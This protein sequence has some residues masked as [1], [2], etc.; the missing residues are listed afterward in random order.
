M[1]IQNQN[2]KEKE[3]EELFKKILTDENKNDMII[4]F[5]CIDNYL[6]EKKPLKTYHESQKKAIKKYITNN[7]ER[8]NEYHRKRHQDK[9]ANDAEYKKKYN[10]R[11]KRNYLKKKEEKK[12]VKEESEKPE[13]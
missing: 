12:K 11:M 13:N 5:E 2:E 8:Y 4:L 6:K 3:I 9:M 1:E 10:E 7:R